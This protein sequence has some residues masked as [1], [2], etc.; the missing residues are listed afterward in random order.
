[1]ALSETR[2]QDAHRIVEAILAAVESHAG[3]AAQSDDIALL[4]VT[5]E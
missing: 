5:R 4:V 2:G 3:G 1:M